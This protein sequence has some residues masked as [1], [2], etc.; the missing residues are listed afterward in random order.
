MMLRRY[1]YIYIYNIYICKILTHSYSNMCTKFG[2]NRSRRSRVML[3]HTNTHTHTY[4]HL[5]IYND[6]CFPELP[7]SDRVTQQPSNRCGNG[8]LRAPS[9]KLLLQR[10]SQYATDP[11]WTLRE[12][13][14]STTHSH[15][16]WNDG[17]TEV[18]TVQRPP[19]IFKPVTATIPISLSKS[20]HSPGQQTSLYFCPSLCATAD[21]NV[22]E[23]FFQCPPNVILTNISCPTQTN[24][25]SATET[26]NCNADSLG[27]WS[28]PSVRNSNLL[29]K[30]D[31]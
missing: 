24:A 16:A 5:Y 25:N 1:I 18:N 21:Q 29:R 20:R 17:A 12:Q 26:V 9:G 28:L 30:H 15:L 13:E 14:I 4:I 6:W 11:L 23:T 8:Q 7:V 22:R 3:E 27:F 19:Q 31:F 2:W 10:R